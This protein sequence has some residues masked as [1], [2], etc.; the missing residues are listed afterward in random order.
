MDERILQIVIRAR[1]EASKV[2]ANSASHIKRSFDDAEEASKRFA[3]GMVG[4]GV[5]AA[6]MIGYGAKIAGDLESSRQGFITL[7]G[8]ADKADAA[9]RQIKKDAAATPFEIPGL[10]SA[11]LLLTSITKDAG[12]SEAILLNVGKALA[13]MGKGQAE[14]DRIIV[15]LQQVGAIGHASLVDIKQFAYAGIPIFDMLTKATGK[16]GEALEE[17]IA[18]GGVTFDFLTDMFNKAGSAGGRFAN[19]FTNQAGTFNQL[20]SNMKDSFNIFLSDLVQSTGAFDVLKGAMA[21][22]IDFMNTN[23]A[24]V[25]EGIMRALTFVRENGLVVAGIIAGALTPAII[26]MA[27]AFGAATLALLP[28]IAAG[29]ALGFLAQTIIANWGPISTVFTDLW[30]SV[31][32]TFQAAVAW[33]GEQVTWLRSHWAEALGFMVGFAATLPI[34][35]PLYMAAAVSAMVARILAVDWRTVLAVI[36]TAAQAI[37]QGVK[38]AAFSAWQFVKNLDWGAILASIGKGIANTIIGFIEGGIRGALSGIPG[39]PKISLPR[40]ADGTNFAPGGLALVGE[41]GPELVNLPRGS[42]VIPNEQTQGMLGGPM[43]QIA[44]VVIRNESDI[45]TLARRLEFYR[46]TG[47]AR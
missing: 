9:L 6:G 31:T 5:A 20:V 33:I 14:L 39:A 25:G 37:F 2:V 11:N 4:A 42:Q 1:D 23:G 29:A 41:R 16:S 21:G 47:G 26:G 3:T 12:K 46:R 40:F 19:A 32:G 15:N 28:Y 24:A 27:L 10:I 35:L 17:M 30:A 36:L 8:S 43:I 18:E 13:S 22:L 45:E 38:D 34:R 44:Q 7:L